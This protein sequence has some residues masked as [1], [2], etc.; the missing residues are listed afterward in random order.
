VGTVPGTSLVVVPA[1]F[2]VLAPTA[3]GVSLDEVSLDDAPLVVVAVEL[4]VDAGAG[5]DVSGER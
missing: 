5:V 3:A 2:D 1:L 4:A